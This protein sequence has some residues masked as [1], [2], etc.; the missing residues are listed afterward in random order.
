MNPTR[1][2]LNAYFEKLCDLLE[3][4][5]PRTHER[6]KDLLNNEINENNYN[7]TE[8]EKFI[9]YLEAAAAFYDERL[10][11]YNP[12][13]IQWTM[14]TPTIDEAFQIESILDWYDSRPEFDALCRTARRMA[15]RLEPDSNDSDRLLQKL[16]HELINQCGAYPNKTIIQ[17]YQNQPQQNHL[18][19]YIVSSLIEQIISNPPA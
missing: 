18:P 9:A 19:D 8:P 14:P 12:I 1:I 16:A 4:A 2:V 15:K 11:S 17:T 10:E 7:I 5:K 6:L 13:G 3:M